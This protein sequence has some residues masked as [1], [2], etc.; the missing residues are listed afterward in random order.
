[1]PPAH[2]VETAARAVSRTKIRTTKVE[3]AQPDHEFDFDAQL[4]M[5]WGRKDAGRMTREEEVPRTDRIWPEV[6]EPVPG[7]FFYVAKLLY[8]GNESVVVPIPKSQAERIEISLI[9]A[10]SW[11][12]PELVDAVTDAVS[13][14]NATNYFEWCVENDM[15]PGTS[16]TYAELTAHTREWTQRRWRMYALHGELIERV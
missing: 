1:M 13:T 7:P 4:P 3:F 5:T 11:T 8:Q 2:P 15:R 14:E 10:Q 12:S 16:E 6:Q 9:Q